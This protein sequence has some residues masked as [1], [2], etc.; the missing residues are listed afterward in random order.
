VPEPRQ[1]LAL[2]LRR[3]A[4]IVGALLRASLMVGMQYRSDFLLDA[5]TGLVRV[6]ATFAP[7]ALVYTSRDSV[8][9]WGVHD[10]TMVL[11]L[12]MLL[13][14]ILEGIIEPNLGA[15]VD[16]IRDGTFDLVLLRPADSQLLVSLRSVAPARMWNAVGGV[17][18]GAWA[19]WHDPPGAALDVAVAGL[20][21]VSGAVGMYGL[22]LIAISSAFLFVRVDNL[23]HLLSSIVDAGRWPVEVFSGWVRWALTVVIPVAVFTSFPAMALRGEWDAAL[24]GVG[25]GVGVAFGVGSR[26]TWRAALARYTSASS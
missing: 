22:W 2:A 8:A 21:L 11:A 25:L 23:R 4:R 20:L 14:A 19:L 15:V 10:A 13:S 16:N 17:G 3:A 7:I 9:G 12:F 24:L 6:A 1:S 18:A 26:I 5:L